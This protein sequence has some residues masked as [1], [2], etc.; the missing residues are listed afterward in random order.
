MIRRDTAL[1]IL[2]IFLAA[3][4]GI[5]MICLVEPWNAAERRL[6][7]QCIEPCIIQDAH[8]AVEANMAGRWDPHNAWSAC[9]AICKSGDPQ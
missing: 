5:L 9:R 8:K 1:G 7:N 2:V 4:S 6:E 3:T